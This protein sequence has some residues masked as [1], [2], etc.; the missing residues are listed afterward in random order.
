MTSV[1]EHQE[2]RKKEKGSYAGNGQEGEGAASAERLEKGEV[3]GEYKRQERYEEEK[4]D[5][6]EGMWG[7]RKKWEKGSEEVRKGASK[8]CVPE[9]GDWMK[10]RK[11]EMRT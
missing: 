4:R 10:E 8:I 6:K 2:K 1:S 3:D 7:E 5:S 11:R 9:K